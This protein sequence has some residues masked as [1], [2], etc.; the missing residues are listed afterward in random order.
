[1]Y[2]TLRTGLVL[3]YVERLQSVVGGEAGGQEESARGGDPVVAVETPED[4]TH[5]LYICTYRIG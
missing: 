2:S 3:R 4:D 1:M 5:I